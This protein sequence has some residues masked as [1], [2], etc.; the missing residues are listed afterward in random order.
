GGNQLNYQHVIDAT[1]GR[2]LYR[3]DNV[4]FEND[5]S[6][7]A[8][9][10]KQRRRH[11][12]G[13]ALVY[14]NY[15][16]AKR[17]GKAHVVN[18][19]KAGFLPRH[20]KSWLK[21]KYVIAWSDLNDNDLADSWEKTPI[22]GNRH[23]AQW[24]LHPFQSSGLCS[25]HYVCTWD[26]DQKFSWRRNRRADVTQ[27]FF[28]D[29]LYHNYLQKAPIGFTP[30]AGN[31]ELRGG[32]PVL[33]NALDGANTN[34]GL[35]DG[36]HIDNANMATPPDGI[37]GTM[38]MY[39]W[40]FPG[41]TDEQ[42][43]F[44]P[45]SGAFAPSVIF[46]EYTHGL[47]NR[48]VVDSQ[49]NST[50]NSIQAGAMGEAWS[51]YY[52]MDYLVSKGYV[53]DNKRSGQV[54]EGSYLMADKAPFRTMAIDCAVGARAKGCTGI[55][56]NRG[57]YTYGEFPTIG[58][59]PEVHS[60]GEVWAQTLWDL[61]KRLGHKRADMIITRAM[62]LSPSDP[63][64][65]DMRNA[66]LQANLAVYGGAKSKRIWHVFAN[67]GM[68]W[69]AGALNAGDAYPVE[70]FHMPPSPETPRATVS[71]QVVNP[72]TDKP[73]AN[74]LVSIGGHDS[75]YTGN[76]TAVTNASG[77]YVISNVYVGNYPLVTV[78]GPGYEV[79]TKSVSVVR[80]GTTANFSPRRDWAASTGGGQVTDFNGPDYS[81]Y[82]CGPAG[83]IDLSQGTGWGSNT[84]DI[85]GDPTNTMIPKYVVVKLPKKVTLSGFAVNPSNT[86]GDP[87]SSSTGDY[88]IETS[89]DG[90]TWSTA[91][92]GT[93]TEGDRQLT[94]VPIDSPVPDVQYVKFWILSPQ[95]PD[96]STTCPEGN[97]GGCTFT[98][99]T[100]LEVFGK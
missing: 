28:F 65:L 43:P 47:S 34:N 4:N 55:S 52:A 80:G 32:D 20:Q 87:G 70:D 38:Q 82:G 85:A 91:K 53:K 22:P 99:M 71:G 27:A 9:S 93:F 76:Y 56:G 59:S 19:Y 90:T 18:L 16:G 11:R 41:T 73:V 45:T 24:R 29:S 67:R 63:S 36:N 89:S 40:H 14:R 88:K 6:R 83:A 49:G 8:Q 92:E 57:G 66:I 15:P 13:D 62:E 72:I 79:L 12:N 75:G 21:G 46:H 94:E 74:A 35:P 33:L 95:V 31:F 30:Q 100:E 5:P 50:L 48:L 96:F 98:D 44:V 2:V 3:H 68:G 17:G 78:F 69:Y 64:M 97:Y 37:P 7:E 51:D 81:A 25:K 61:R 58:G 84:G 10:K 60:S 26:P 39:L 54:F 1:T 86:C 42:D 23:R 77:H